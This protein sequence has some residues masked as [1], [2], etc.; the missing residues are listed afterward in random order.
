[1]LRAA[2]ALTLLGL[3]SACS[4]DSSPSGAGAQAGVGGSGSSGAGGRDSTGGSAAAG[5]SS[6]L[7][8]P[9]GVVVSLFPPLDP[10]PGYSTLL[11]RFFSGPQPKIL[12]LEPRLELGECTLFVPRAPFCAEP[13]S[14]AVCTDD[15][16]CTDYPEPR[17]VG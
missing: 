12:A 13:C 16:V 10:D 1:M 6:A 17:P 2:V 4:S 14:P 9:G 7:G 15:D 11:G 3:L 8:L 5:S